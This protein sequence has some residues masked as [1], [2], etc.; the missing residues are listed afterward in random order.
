MPRRRQRGEIGHSV[1]ARTSG[2]A[3]KRGLAWTRSALKMAAFR[4][5]ELLPPERELAVRCGISRRTMRKVL[6]TLAQE[7]SVECQPRVGYRVSQSRN[8]MVSARTGMVGFIH[9]DFTSLA[10]SHRYVAV[11][12][13]LLADS[14]HMLALG[15]SGRDT[16]R[17]N[18][19]I[20]QFRQNKAVALVVAPAVTG[21]Q[22]SELE[23]WIRD[24]FS[25]V[26]YGHAKLWRMDPDLV[27]RCDQVDIDNQSG[28]EQAVRHLLSL[29]HH[30]IA[31]L[32]HQPL[33]HTARYPAFVETL[34]SS[35]INVRPEWLLGGPAEETLGGRAILARLKESESLPTAVFC[36][37]DNIALGFIEAM[38]QAGLRCPEDISVISFSN[39]SREGADDVST[40]TT[41]DFNS[42]TA[43]VK[44]LR[45]LRKQLGGDMD[46]PERVLLPV[47]LQI[48]QSTGVPLHGRQ[49]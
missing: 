48:R 34:Q 33:N 5:G 12:E 8:E 37:D 18:A 19:W 15:A 14:G 20:R 30:D 22:S 17:E 1:R 40:L 23:A 49:E 32:S 43:A 42:D 41:V 28:T 9:R 35:G 25:V 47:H 39:E 21:G 3:Y 6:D 16:E 44:T 36:T 10:C 24:G 2:G 7:G 13:S 38:E 11:L 31:F 27:A 29:G 4:S 45:L 46:Y 26:L